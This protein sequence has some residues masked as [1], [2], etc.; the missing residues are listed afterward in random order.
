MYIEI[1]LLYYNNYTHIYNKSSWFSYHEE[2]WL[3]SF[4]SFLFCSHTSTGY[5]V[6][7]LF[8]LFCLY[9]NLVVFFINKQNCHV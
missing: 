2:G 6:M 8:F 4:C 9:F 1:N 3:V 5:S 7:F